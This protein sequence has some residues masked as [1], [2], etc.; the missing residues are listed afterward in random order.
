MQEPKAY[1]ALG[2]DDTQIVL[3]LTSEPNAFVAIA[4]VSKDN[5]DFALESFGSTFS[6]S[7]QVPRAYAN[8]M[9]ARE[10]GT[11]STRSHPR[12]V[13]PSKPFIHISLLV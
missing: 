4:Y 12:Y 3:Y 11:Q 2:D 6:Q 9:E 10:I 5:A 1:S 13:P 8:Q 7:T